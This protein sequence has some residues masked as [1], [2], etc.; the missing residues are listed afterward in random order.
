MLQL[1][2][3]FTTVDWDAVA[4]TEHPGDPGI[5]TWRTVHADNVRLRRVSYSPGYAADHWCERG[6][7]IFVLDGTLV[8]ELADGRVFVTEAGNSYH[9]ADGASSHRSSTVTGVELFIVD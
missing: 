8:T 4:Q 5:A 1:T 3:E 7:V 2:T 9:V 6:H